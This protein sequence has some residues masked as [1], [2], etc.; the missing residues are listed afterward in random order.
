[1]TYTTFPGTTSVNG[2][3]QSTTAGTTNQPGT[4][5]TG[6]PFGGQGF[7]GQTI[8]N[9]QH[10]GQNPTGQYN[11]QFNGQYGNP[12]GGQYGGQFFGGYVTTPTGFQ[13]VPFFATP[14]NFNIGQTDGSTFGQNFG[15]NFNQPF[16]QIHPFGQFGGSPFVHGWNNTTTSPFGYPV[17]TTPTFNGFPAQTWNSFNGSTIPAWYQGRSFNGWFGTP[18]NYSPT[19]FNWNTPFNFSSPFNYGGNTPFSS[20]WNTPFN[21]NWNTPTNYGFQHPSQTSGFFGGVNGW[22]SS[23]PFNSG[24]SNGSFNSTPWSIH[25]FDNGW[26]SPFAT[27]FYPGAFGYTGGYGITPNFINSISGTQIP[28][29][30]VPAFPF[31]GSVN[32]TGQTGAFVPTTGECCGIR[33]A[34]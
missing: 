32:T 30:G 6:Q 17:N 2:I 8:Q 9:G 25:S 16:G 29:Y 23:T 19:S 7:N 5:Y 31:G 20:H 11:S 28:V 18:F 4:G 24:F 22:N 3:P 1:M 27:G 34:A 14:W 10:F 13:Y 26:M 33:Q 21:Y 12:F 15:F